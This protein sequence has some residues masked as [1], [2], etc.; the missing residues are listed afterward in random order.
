MTT[1]Q[2][3]S[4]PP[5]NGGQSVHIKNLFDYM[6]K[7][8]LD[9]TVFNTGKTKNIEITGVVNIAS[10]FDLLKKLMFRAGATMHLH[11]GRLGHL[12]SVFV[13]GFY[14]I[15]FR[16]R[17]VV[18]LHSGGFE[19]DFNHLSCMKRWFL[20]RVLRSAATVICVNNAIE[21]SL[22]KKNV[23]GRKLR[24]IPAFSLCTDLTDLRFDDH[25]S[26]F[27]GRHEPVIVCMGFLEP[28][29]GMALAV[30]AL[31]VLK[32]EFPRIGLVLLASGGN[33]DRFIAQHIDDSMHPAVLVA[34]NEPREQCLLAISRCNLFLRPTY[35]DGDAV[36]VREALAFGTPV[37]ASETD[38]RPAGVVLFEIGNLSDLARTAR[39]MLSDPSS[40]PSQGSLRI[41]HT[42]NLER[43]VQCLQAS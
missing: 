40:R 11:F 7:S 23:E 28:H 37:L 43:I 19:G 41:K 39:K 31:G 3:G 2:I 26:S 12:G 27:F 24:V 20:L 9:C 17:L 4:Y 36:S 18:T 30:Q 22:M 6:K 15:V 13:C 32:R 29:Y 38:F 1:I 8:G 25:L 35:F 5:P 16:R 14:S 42:E 34:V 10:T 21:A 33:K